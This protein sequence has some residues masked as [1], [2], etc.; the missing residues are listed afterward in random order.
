[1]SIINN[2]DFTLST[3]AQAAIESIC[4]NLALKDI[5]VGFEY[6]GIYPLFNYETDDYLISINLE[7][8]ESKHDMGG[9]VDSFFENGV[10]SISGNKCEEVA[11]LNDGDM[12]YGRARALWQTEVSHDDDY[13]QWETFDEDKKERRKKMAQRE[14]DR[15]YKQAN[16]LAEAA[17]TY[18][19]SNF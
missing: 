2:N 5:C 6:N 17:Q 13:D 8:L 3:K 16:F 9:L 1:M 14:K 12:E 19:E 4:T 7:T 18:I 10:F 15:L 11:N